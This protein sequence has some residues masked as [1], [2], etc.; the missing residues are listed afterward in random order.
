LYQRVEKIN[1]TLGNKSLYQLIKITAS[2]EEICAREK[3]GTDKNSKLS[4]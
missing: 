1:F 2:R 4:G 3:V